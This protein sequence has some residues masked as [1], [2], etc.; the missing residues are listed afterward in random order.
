[1]KSAA[2]RVKEIYKGKDF[3]VSSYTD[4]EMGSYYK[5][6]MDREQENFEWCEAYESVMGR[7]EG[8]NKFWLLKYFMPSYHRAK[9]D[10][11]YLIR[12][13]KFYSPLYRAIEQAIEAYSLKDKYVNRLIRYINSGLDIKVKLNKDALNFTIYPIYGNPNNIRELKVRRLSDLVRKIYNSNKDE[14]LTEDNIEF[15][16][17][18]DSK[19]NKNDCHCDAIE[20]MVLLHAPNTKLV[21]AFTTPLCDKNPVYHTWIE[22]ENKSGEVYCLD[23]NLNAIVPKELYY[24]IKNPEF[25]NMSVIDYQSFKEDFNS[26]FL[27]SLSGIDIKQYLAFRN[28][29]KDDFIKNNFIEEEK[30]Q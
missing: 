22:L 8:Y 6:F 4:A 1:M 2:D 14:E 18:L 10:Y 21:T 16:E 11:D 5:L 3:F 19:V 24:M 27:K 30:Q 17:Y 7:L 13:C 12:Q 25:D 29:I 23:T 26:G 15:L 9:I 20:T 28:E